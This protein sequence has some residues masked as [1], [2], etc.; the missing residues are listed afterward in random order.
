VS[1]LDENTVLA[2]VDGRLDGEA[3]SSAESHVASC[4]TC[5]D[6]VAAAAGASRALASATAAGAGPALTKG[7]SVGRHVILGLVG[8]GGMGDVYAAYDPELDRKVALKVLRSRSA[9]TAD[10]EARLLREAQA[11]AKLSHPNVVVVYEV[12]T[13]RDDVFIAM[14]FVEGVT[15]GRWLAQETR[16]IADILGVFLAAGR[17]LGAAHDAG[18]IHRDF[19]PENVMVTRDGQVRVMDFGL[20]R[21]LVSE[22][23]AA[24]DAT[25]GTAAA[26][27]YLQ[28]K[29]T[30]TGVQV[31]TPAYMAPEQFRS[32]ERI[33]AR[34][35]QFSFCVALYEALHGERPFRGDSV[36]ALRDSVLGGKLRPPPAGTRVPAWLRRVLL[37]GLSREP[38]ARW[39]SMAALLAALDRDPRARHRRALVAGGAVA[40]MVGLAVAGHRIGSGER[41][42]CTGGGARLAGIWEPAGVASERKQAIHRAFVATGVPYA[43]QAF[44]AAA[45]LL[46]DWAG[47]W[48][49]LYKDACE[50][51]HLRGEQSAEVLDLRMACLQERLGNVRALSDVFAAA[52]PGVV[53]NAPS[54]AGALPGLDRCSDV[55]LLRAVVK[56]PDDPAV[57][58]RVDELRGKLAHLVA[59]RNAGRCREA[60]AMSGDL[61]AAVRATSYRPLL[62]ET[63]NAAAVLGNDC[64]EPALAVD[65]MKEAYV[66]ASA[67]RDDQ[68]AAEAA[69]ML[70]VFAVNRLGDV[71]LAR[72]WLR[73]AEGALERLGD[74]PVI[75]SWLLQ[76]EGIVR[77]T[78]HDYEGAVDACRRAVDIKQR[79]F[80]PDHPETILALEIEATALEA[81]GRLEEM[82]RTLRATQVRMTRVLG[83]EHPAMARSLSNEGEVLELLGRHVE[84]HAAYER[85]LA[86]WRQAGSDRVYLSYG[87]TGV[88]RALLGEGRAADAVAPLEEALA[89]REQ[90]HVPPV[91]I[92]E[93][94]FALARALGAR[95]ASRPRAL[96]LARRAR[97]DLGGADPKIAAEIDAWLSRPRR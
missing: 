24:E 70:P 56:P 30:Q 8:R 87:L 31:G 82:L 38:A 67:G 52:D 25:T 23:G 14:E 34:T 40:L 36:G 71:A 96:E 59:T 57:R 41:T 35:D 13:V 45:R 92:A 86:I 28:L 76:S 77:T 58:K 5:A 2:F 55:A 68:A 12:G 94:R 72:D 62:A 19:K 16:T 43:E 69:A 81:A 60:L 7:D 54:A 22:P 65:R 95:S 3:L 39:E 33:D 37:R 89:I 6:L 78:E 75:Q 1:C 53:L 79:L 90:N 29:I 44:A 64:G 97:T 46:D 4:Q 49:A 10:G 15:V 63:L 17:G 26:A 27:A 91:D 18:I 48:A 20:A 47:R 85:A 51:T 21:P 74:N 84:S 80:G 9:R 93:T 73:I 66:V 83:A 88:G 42:V 50:A 61:I 11:I 32:G